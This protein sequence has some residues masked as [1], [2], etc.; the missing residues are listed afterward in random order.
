M[1]KGRLGRYKQDRFI[2]YFISEPT[3]PVVATLCCVS[4]KTAAFF[5]CRR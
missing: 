4:R 1:R 5:V 3:A 2:E